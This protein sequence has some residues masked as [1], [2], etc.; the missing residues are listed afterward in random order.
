M[1]REK[2]KQREGRWERIRESKYSKW[3]KE[4]KGEGIPEHLKK[5][6]GKVGVGE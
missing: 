1:D 5:G 3:Y 4:V 6:G 2:E